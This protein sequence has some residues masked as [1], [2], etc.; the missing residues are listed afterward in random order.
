MSIILNESKYDTNARPT[1]FW[2]RTHSIAGRRCKC[3]TGFF[4][5]S[6]FHLAVKFISH[7][8][9][10]KCFA[11][12]G[13]IGLQFLVSLSDCY[14]GKDGEKRLSKFALRQNIHCD[15]SQTW[16]VLRHIKNTSLGELNWNMPTEKWNSSLHFVN[17]LIS[18]AKSS[19]YS[20]RIFESL[21]GNPLRHVADAIVP[22]FPPRNH[23]RI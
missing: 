4:R 10:S 7:T 13:R 11:S 5:N 6:R 3:K 15:M 22:I 18:T 9:I 16:I 21:V 12:Y 2:I 20:R 8:H 23:F 14:P 1:L 19:N 17:R